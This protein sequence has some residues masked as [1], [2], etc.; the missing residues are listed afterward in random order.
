MLNEEMLS[1]LKRDANKAIKHKPVRFVDVDPRIL[2]SLIDEIERHRTTLLIV[3]RKQLDP[4]LR[5]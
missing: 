1:E 5:D 3:E 2:A 4:A